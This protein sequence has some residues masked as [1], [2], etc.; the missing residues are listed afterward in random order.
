[1]KAILALEDGSTFEGAAVGAGGERMGEV[2]LNTAVVGYQEIVTDPANAGKIVVLTY[3]LIG[4]YGA[5]AKFSESE[6]CWASALVMKERSRTVSNWQAQESLDDFIK[7]EKLVAIEGVDTRTLAVLIR[8]KGQMAG[9]VST[10]KSDRKGLMR[11]LSAWKKKAKVDFISKVSVGK[12]R[13][14]R[15]RKGGPTVG[16]LD[17]GL[18][19]GFVSQL[20]TLGCSLAVLPYDTSAESILGMK[21]DGLVLCGGPEEDEAIP[22]VVDQVRKLLGKVPMLGICTGHEVIAL[23]LGGR[24]E[25]MKVG[26]R[27]VNYPVRT[28]DSFKGE[29]TVQNHSYIVDEKSLAA[30]KGV[31]ITLRN[32]ND[33]SV[34]EMRSGSLRFISTQYYPVSPGFEEVNPVFP[35][36]LAMA[37]KKGK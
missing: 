34:E 17:L 26:H 6:R 37:R 24:L 32:V 16:I 23:A 28:P 9:I 2:I 18:R 4:N 11:K 36:F 3:P 20:R 22:S 1:M 13:R 8:E 25:K 12:V 5:A 30:Q 31:K 29:I 35:A 15:G 21:L 10:K 27:G 14:I 19:N 33:N 7:K